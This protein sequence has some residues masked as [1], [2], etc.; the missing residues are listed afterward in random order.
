MFIRYLVTTL[1]GYWPFWVLSWDVELVFPFV[2][3]WKKSVTLLALFFQILSVS[4]FWFFVLFWPFCE[5]R[6]KIQT[7]PGSEWKEPGC[8]SKRSFSLAADKTVLVLFDF[9]FVFFTYN[10]GEGSK[11]VHSCSNY[12]FTFIPHP[13][14]L[15]E[16][17]F[18][19]IDV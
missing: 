7:L 3:H 12:L 11:K 17:I 6:L 19:M 14:F 13:L 9:L 1:C 18:V 5:K 10:C 15:D 2:F 16:L 8:R 4:G